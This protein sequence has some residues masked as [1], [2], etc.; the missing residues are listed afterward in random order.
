MH[1]TTLQ[2]L[3]RSN[4]T[5]DWRRFVLDTE[6][7][8]STLEL[9]GVS[10]HVAL[11]LLQA[12]QRIVRI[13]PP[14]EERRAEALIDAGLHSAIQIASIPKHV[15]LTQWSE[16]FPEE[17]A[18]AQNVYRAALSRRSELLHQ[19]LNEVQRNE[20]HYRATRFK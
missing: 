6:A 7:S 4:P 2:T 20:P 17:E 1:D 13:L 15:F 8:L 9:D 19:H 12:Y 5:T 3:L 10:P 18:L 14:G 11:P 16:L